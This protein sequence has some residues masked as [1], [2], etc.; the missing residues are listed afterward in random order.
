M[1]STRSR[2]PRAALASRSRLLAWA[3]LALT[4]STGLLHGSGCAL[5]GPGEPLVYTSDSPE[6][7]GASVQDG[8]WESAPWEGAPWLS[9]PPRTT[10]V[11]EHTLGR[12]PRAVWV[13]LA[14]D[15]E[16]TEPALAAGDLARI[17]AV[18]E[19]SVSVRND[20]NAGFYCRVVAF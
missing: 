1:R 2:E 16:G 11:L 5:P 6:L 15:P 12:A 3:T 9:F 20:T 7:A 14:F 10:L 17:S 18:S 4:V 13:Y 8:V 19:T